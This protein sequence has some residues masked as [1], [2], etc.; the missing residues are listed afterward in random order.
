[1]YKKI[2]ITAAALII[3]A[4]G[5]FALSD[6]DTMRA[7]REIEINQDMINRTLLK[8][9]QDP[10]MTL[11]IMKELDS[12]P[13]MMRQFNIINSDINFKNAVLTEVKKNPAAVNNI[14]VQMIN[15]PAFTKRVLINMGKDP[16][17][18]DELAKD[19]LYRRKLSDKVQSDPEFMKKIYNEIYIK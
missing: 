1:M 10:Q 8:M 13:H 17:Y 7:M 14:T 12:N 15:D 3:A 5:S 6:E 2:L 9:Q 11:K 18:A 4:Q 16:R 19:P